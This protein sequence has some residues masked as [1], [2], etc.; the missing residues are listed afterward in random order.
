MVERDCTTTGFTLYGNEPNTRLLLPISLAERLESQS[1]ITAQKSAAEKI[2]IAV[3]Q[4]IESVPPAIQYP[5]HK[6]E[7]LLKKIGFNIESIRTDTNYDL[8]DAM[9]LASRVLAK[10]TMGLDRVSVSF[11]NDLLIAITLELAYSESCGT[12]IDILNF[13]CDPRWCNSKQILF[14]FFNRR[15]AFQ[16]KDAAAW[17]Q[18]FNR[19]LKKLTDDEMDA[20]VE[21]CYQH[22]TSA[23]Q[24]KTK[25]ASRGGVQVFDPEALERAVVRVKEFKDDRRAAGERILQKTHANN[26]KRALPNP[27][28]AYAKLELAKSRFENL[29]EPIDR[30]QMD[31]ILS[32]AMKPS[33]FRITPML[34][35]GEPGIGKT[36]LAT[37]LARALGVSTEKISAGG[38]QGGFQLTGSHSS[39]TGSRPGMLFSL[40]GEGDSAAPVVVI[41]EVEKI[42]DAQYPIL[43]VLLDLLDAGSS[44]QF[45][46]EFFELHFDASHVIFV[47]TA[48]SIDDV[49]PALLSRV[50]VFDVPAPKPAQRLRIIQ[51]MVGNLCRTTRR[52]I[53]LDDSSSEALSQRIDIDL[54]RVTRLVNEAFTRALQVGDE[55]AYLSLPKNAGKRSIGFH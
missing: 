20:L 36:F 46:D 7:E 21:T 13:I 2:A 9:T 31:L 51:E 42:K 26:G 30:I 1:E 29:V 14:S 15:D 33:E 18:S 49:P 52:R 53:D 37:Q 50:E 54:R 3:K 27:K 25:N 39:W 40:L 11:S 43:P 34:L 48:N 8:S 10:S 41:D 5:L 17:L 38:A 19:K 32:A 6:N 4:S 35:L 47:M 24:P 28:A 22:W 44:K 45:K 12:L 16:Q 23:G 55:V